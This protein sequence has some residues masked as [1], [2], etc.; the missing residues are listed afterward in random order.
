MDEQ[1]CTFRGKRYRFVGNPAITC[2]CLSNGQKC[3]QREMLPV[4]GGD[5]FIG[6]FG[7]EGFLCTK[8]WKEITSDAKRE[9]E[10]EF[11][12]ET[13]ADALMRQC[14]SICEKVP[15]LEYY[16][17]TNHVHWKIMNPF[18]KYAGD[19]K[20]LGTIEEGVVHSLKMAIRLITSEKKNFMEGE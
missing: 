6:S 8:V 9:D 4:D 15:F 12:S 14:Y 19:K 2:K 3:N 10:V 16:S 1:T 20:V 18:T 5:H 17:H 13:D 7:P 11:W